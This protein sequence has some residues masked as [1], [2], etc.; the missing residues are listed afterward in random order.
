MKNYLIYSL[1]LAVLV[2]GTLNFFNN[3]SKKNK[4]ELLITANIA[5]DSLTA[6]DKK[7][8]EQYWAL[9]NAKQKV[10]TV[11]V[12]KKGDVVVIY[13]DTA[14]L[15]ED[16][17]THIKTLNDSL[18][19]EDLTLKYLMKYS[20]EIYNIK[21]FYEVK[22]KTVTVENIVN[23]PVPY[24]VIREVPINT[25]ALYLGAV[26]SYPEIDPFINATYLDKKR[27]L[28]SFSYA[29]ISKS[30]LVGYSFKIF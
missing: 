11:I 17:A 27:G 19:T 2:F 14:T 3:K 5:I 10:D 26:L 21:F 20:G 16:T 7:S 15:N 4:K 30:Y 13:K 9:Y 12:E 1:I 28:Y 22:Q 8:T 29:P 6:K 24:E 18:K 25:R 23:V